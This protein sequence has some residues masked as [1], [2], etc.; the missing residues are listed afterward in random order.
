M[1]PWGVDM[2][3]VLLN[4]NLTP[5]LLSHCLKQNINIKVKHLFIYFS[6]KK[7]QETQTT[8]YESIYLY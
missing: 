6:K 2:L 8:A 5:P 7:E 3:S 1:H 4:S